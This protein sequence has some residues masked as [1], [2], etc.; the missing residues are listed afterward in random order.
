MELKELDIEINRLEKRIE[1][2]RKNMEHFIEEFIDATKNFSIDW[3]KKLIVEG[4]KSEPNI[5]LGMERGKLK[6][7][8]TKYED[9]LNKL[10]EIVENEFNDDETWKQRLLFDN[11]NVEDITPYSVLIGEIKNNI[12]KHCRKILGYTGKLLLDYGYYK[13]H[14]YRSPWKETFNGAL[15]YVSE[16]DWSPQM[17]YFAKDY[18]ETFSDFHKSLSDLKSLKNNKAQMEAQKIWD[19]L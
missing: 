1:I 19:A 12:D 8:K 4:I 6:E 14:Q 3:T 13:K 18:T 7:L 10:P 5:T 16:L 15:K 17:K 9:L 11:S 2:E